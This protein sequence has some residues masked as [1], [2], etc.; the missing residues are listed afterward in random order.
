MAIAEDRARKTAQTAI[1][2]WDASI[3]SLAR[4]WHPRD[5][6]RS[7]KTAHERQLKPPRDK[8]SSLRSVLQN[9]RIGSQRKQHKLWMN[10][11]A[12]FQSSWRPGAVQELLHTHLVL[13]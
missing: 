7:L 11:D 2:L 12:C 8:Y 5:R 13:H 1:C 9:E 4:S 10:P 6:W 3:V